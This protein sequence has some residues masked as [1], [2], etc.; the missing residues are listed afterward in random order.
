[1]NC[2]KQYSGI[3]LFSLCRATNY[4]S[5]NNN[6]CKVLIKIFADSKSRV[7]DCCTCRKEILTIFYEYFAIYDQVYFN[8]IEMDME[9]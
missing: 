9:I 8:V 5:Y 4:N 2:G 7:R 1:M 6:F 3:L